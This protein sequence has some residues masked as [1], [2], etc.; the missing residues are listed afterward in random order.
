MSHTDALQGRAPDGQSLPLL[1][2]AWSPEELITRAFT[3]VF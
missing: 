2:T 1:L 3:T